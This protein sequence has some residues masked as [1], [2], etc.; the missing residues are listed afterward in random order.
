MVDMVPSSVLW[1]GDADGFTGELLPRHLEPRCDKGMLYR[2][3]QMSTFIHLQWG[4]QKS[5]K[6]RNGEG[7]FPEVAYPR[8]ERRL[9]EIV[10]ILEYTALKGRCSSLAPSK[11]QPYGIFTE[12]VRKLRAPSFSRFL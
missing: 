3:L 6:I 4:C 10:L 2:K 12:G 8:G 1:F 7:A 9:G 11:P 5:S